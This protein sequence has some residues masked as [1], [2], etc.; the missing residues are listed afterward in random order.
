MTIEISLLIS[1]ISVTFAIYFGL[2]NSKRT[3]TKDIEARV[4]QNTRINMK[5]DENIRLSQDTKAEI[6]MLKADLQRHNDK[7]IEIEASSKAAHRRL[8]SFEGRLNSV[9]KG[10]I[11][12]Q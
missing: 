9:E 3:D 6:K 5:L 8:D 2:K 12:E 11:N 7:I 10:I 4:E 1:A